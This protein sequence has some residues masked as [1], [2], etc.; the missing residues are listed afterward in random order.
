MKR[1]FTILSGMSLFAC[2]FLVLF[3]CGDNENVSKP[4]DDKPEISVPTDRTPFMVT[5][6]RGTL[7]Y[8]ETEKAW[9]ISPERK[10]PGMF[11]QLG[12]CEGL[13]MMI[14]KMKKEYESLAGQISFS[15]KVTPK[16]DLLYEASVVVHVY[17][18]ELSNISSVEEG[19]K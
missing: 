9:I 16:H 13:Y 15:G 14:S 11:I 12:P 6:L 17:T 7:S 3:A 10:Q 19:D 8:D 1:L 18:I 5:D 4:H 2:L